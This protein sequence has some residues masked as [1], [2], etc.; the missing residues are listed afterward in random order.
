MTR[1]VGDVVIVGATPPGTCELCGKMAELRPY[2]PKGE[3]ICFACGQLDL[4]ATQAAMIKRLFGAW[5]Q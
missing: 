1:C 5:P 4:K 2:G 3:E